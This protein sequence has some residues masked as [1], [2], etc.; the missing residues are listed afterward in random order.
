[1]VSK[2]DKNVLRKEHEE[3]KNFTYKLNECTLSFQLHTGVKHKMQD[4]AKLLAEALVEVTGII[5]KNWPKGD[6]A[7]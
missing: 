2:L 3:L 4:Y 5:E 6:K 1:M 7:K